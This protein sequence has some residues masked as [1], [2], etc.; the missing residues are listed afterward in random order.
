MK[1]KELYY[2]LICSN[3][4]SHSRVNYEIYC[5]VSLQ[6]IKS[7]QIIELL[8]VFEI[9]ISNNNCMIAKKYRIWIDVGLRS[10]YKHSF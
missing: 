4:H 3:I 6:Y 10:N 5:V 9:N 8:L 1:Y 7:D 2:F